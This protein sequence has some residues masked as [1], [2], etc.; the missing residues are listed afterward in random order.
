MSKG[1]ET[2]NA[3]LDRA[4]SLAKT[5]GLEGLSIGRLAEDLQLSKSGLFAHFKSK[6]ALQLEVIR[7]ARESFVARV[8]APALKAPRGEPRV[9]A[10]YE[11]WIEWG[12]QQGGCIFVTLSVELDDRPGPARDAV[13]ASQRD[14]FEALTT[15]ASIAIKEK[16]FRREL[17]PEQFAFEMYSLMFGLHHFQRILDDPQALAR[18]RRAFESLIERS[19]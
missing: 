14:W 2:R 6:E 15:A 8:M 4:L 12:Q 11:R 19:R 9:R 10:L 13:K 1:E 3:I 7:V 5:V 17:D 16:H 18:T